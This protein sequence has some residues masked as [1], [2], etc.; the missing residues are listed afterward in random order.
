MVWIY[1]LY[2]GSA[3]VGMDQNKAIVILVN[4]IGL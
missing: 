3:T 1:C 2:F 4:F